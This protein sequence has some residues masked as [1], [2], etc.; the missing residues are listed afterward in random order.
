MQRDI[1]IGWERA[2]LGTILHDPQAMSEAEMLMP[3]D[4]IGGHQLI[5]AEMLALHHRE[6]LDYRAVV[7]S[8]R[9]QDN[10]DSVAPIMGED[11][12]EDY[13]DHLL[14]YRGG[15]VREYVDQVSSA[16]LKR[17][18]GRVAALIRIDAEN[19]RMDAQE[20]ADE[21]ER[22]LLQ[23]RRTRGVD[24]GTPLSSVISVFNSRVEGMREGTIQ[25]AWTPSIDPIRNI[26]QFVDQDDFVVIAARPGEGKSSVMR[27]EFV[28]AAEAGMPV[29]LFNLENGEL[30]YAKF[31]ISM[32]TGINSD[33]LK[34]P[35][36]L[37]PD[38]IDMVRQ[39]SGE[40]A[41]LP[42]YIKTMGSP[43][44]KEINR[45]ANQH[46]SR[47]KVQLIGLDYVQLVRNGISRRVDDVSE[48]TGVLRGMAINY[49]TPI[50]ANAQLSREIEHRGN[51]ANPVLADLRDSGSLE[52][53]AT[54]VWFQRFFW[55]EPS[56]VQLGIFRENV[57]PDGGVRLPAKAVPV[58]TFILKN[59]NGGVGTTQPYLW[60]KATNNFKPITNQEDLR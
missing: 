13:L 28:K 34:D 1:A 43:S 41:Q 20:A 57:D 12:G 27:Y 24:E 15:A 14:T 3:S 37:R 42:L 59:R 10:L 18:L 29:L 9:G 8:L 17:E 4:F 22:R 5:W 2:L 7:E 39:A 54:M 46:V 48:T 25:P 45:V 36:L 47:H 60:V 19:E 11:G 26:V 33:K 31:A 51:N 6:A 35:R 52:Q 50:I 16:S 40:L 38:E 55:W 30:E 53:D 44:I 49:K 58:R 56:T 23:L 32:R 21:A